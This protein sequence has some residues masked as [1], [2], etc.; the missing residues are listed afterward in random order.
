MI[1]PELH[2]SAWINLKH[3]TIHKEKQVLEAFD[4]YAVPINH[5]N[6]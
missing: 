6:M 4:Y 3:V 2:A 5:E 1:E